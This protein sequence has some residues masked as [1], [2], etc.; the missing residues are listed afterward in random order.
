MAVICQMLD[1]VAINYYNL[2]EQTL[3]I[4]RSQD[5]DIHIE[6]PS[7]S[8]KHAVIELIPESGTEKLQY[9]IKDLE[10]TNATIV[11]GEKI[12]CHK[13][14]NNDLIRIGFTILKFIDD[15]SLETTDTVKI[16]KSWIPGVYYTK[17]PT[18]E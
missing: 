4:G 2:E 12:S 11:N 10:S 16:K 5:N 18:E 15:T 14:K 9:Q 13:L 3:H 1:G 8:S 17:K 6:E 7:V